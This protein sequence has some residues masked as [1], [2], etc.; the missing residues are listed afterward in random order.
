MR[1]YEID[2]VYLESGNQQNTKRIS[3]MWEIVNKPMNDAVIYLLATW[4]G[5]IRTYSTWLL[6]YENE[7]LIAVAGPA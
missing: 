2:G 4:Q 7:R 6:A 1:I 3:E 5:L